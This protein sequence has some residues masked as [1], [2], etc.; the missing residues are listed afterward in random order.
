MTGRVHHVG[1][2][3]SEH[4]HHQVDQVVQDRGAV[5]SSTERGQDEE[6]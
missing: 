5:L 2:H 3:Q 1:G 6:N 4:D